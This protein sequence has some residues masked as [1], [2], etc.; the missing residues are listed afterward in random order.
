MRFTLCSFKHWNCFQISAELDRTLGDTECEIR[1]EYSFFLHY[2]RDILRILSI[3]F[4]T[5]LLFKGFLTLIITCI[6]KCKIKVSKYIAIWYFTCASSKP[7]AP[8]FDG[9]NNWNNVI[10]RS[11]VTFHRGIWYSCFLCCM[12]KNSYRFY[13]I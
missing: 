13:Y 12:L 5:F 11:K 9:K 2:S 6:K 7:N 3:A 4:C 8:K 1:G 10:Y